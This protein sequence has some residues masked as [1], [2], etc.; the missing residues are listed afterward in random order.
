MAPAAERRID[1]CIERRAFVARATRLQRPPSV[2]EVALQ[3]ADEITPIWLMTEAELAQQGLP[4]PFWSFA[5]VGGQGVARYVIDH[6]AAVAGARVLDLAAGSGLCGIA[7]A[8]AGARSVLAAD[9]D[10]FCGAAIALN[11]A[12][13]G[14]DVEFTD[15]DLLA[16]DPPAVDV[17]LAGDV[18]YEQQMSRQMLAWL[19][20][21]AGTGVSVLLGDPG[22]AY[23]ATSG[24]RL[25]AECEIVTTPE[26]EDA[27]S[28]HTRVYAV[29]GRQT[30][31]SGAQP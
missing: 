16:G 31:E 12:A 27:T 25:L 13:N 24:L 14:V 18:C 6:P 11:A 21:A 15:A 9:I 22:R 23:L 8:L 20:R 19:A 3:L 5:W 4:P 26:L 10:P 17:V 28:K 2:P 7:A 1:R 29:T 30:S